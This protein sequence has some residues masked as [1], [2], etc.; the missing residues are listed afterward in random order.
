M[1][2]NFF[3]YFLY[4]DYLSH[5]FVFFCL[6]MNAYIFFTFCHNF[7]MLKHKPTDYFV[8]IFCYRFGKEVY[9]AA[10]A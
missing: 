8:T 5:F 10:L 3:L 9:V 2:A 4:N 1:C 7:E 6:I